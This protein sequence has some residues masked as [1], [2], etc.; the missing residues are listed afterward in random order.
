MTLDHVRCTENVIQYV[1]ELNHVINIDK[2][3]YSL[4]DY[5]S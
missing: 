4:Y 1:L 3:C 5:V 2:S